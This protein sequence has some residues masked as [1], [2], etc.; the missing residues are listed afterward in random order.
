[1]LTGDRNS[2]ELEAVQQNLLKSNE[3]VCL[4]RHKKWNAKKHR[5]RKEGETRDGERGGEGLRETEG[6]KERDVH[7]SGCS[8][9]RKGPELTRNTSR[10]LE[11]QRISGGSPTFQQNQQC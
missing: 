5:N 9:T 1:M 10:V 11:K 6:E 7:R 8:K 4:K 2:L 3:S